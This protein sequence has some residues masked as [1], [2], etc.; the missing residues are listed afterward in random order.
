MTFPVAE[1]VELIVHLY[2]I[3]K[4]N[5]LKRYGIVYYVSSKMKYAIL[6]NDANKAKRVKNQLEKLHFVR[7]VEISPIAKLSTD[8]SEVLENL[9]NETEDSPDNQ[10]RFFRHASTFMEE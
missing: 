6:Y 10:W 7:S 5:T 8:F 3:K 9:R 4:V 1:R 2:S